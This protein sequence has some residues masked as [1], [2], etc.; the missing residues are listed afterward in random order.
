MASWIRNLIMLAVLLVWVPYMIVS[1]IRAVSPD[2]F[3]WGVPGAVYFALNPSWKRKEASNTPT[4]P[5]GTTLR[6]YTGP[7][8]L[9]LGVL[10][11]TGMDYIF[12]SIVWLVLLGPVAGWLLGKLLNRTWK[13]QHPKEVEQ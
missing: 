13:K 12:K 11:S 7:A 1:L 4:E 3:V 10:S 2:P 8:L 5:D 6:N 9:I